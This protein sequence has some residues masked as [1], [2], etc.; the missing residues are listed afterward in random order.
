VAR[1]LVVDDEP[2]FRT[3]VALVLEIAGHRVMLAAD[4]LEALEAS[5]LFDLLVTDLMMPRMM[6]HELARRMRQRHPT[7]KVL[8][9]TGHTA[10]LFRNKGR[11]L[12]GEAVLTKPVSP[13]LLEDTVSLLL[14]GRIANVVAAAP[15]TDR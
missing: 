9:L 4:G 6:G 10:E 2:S 8:Y 11:L 3:F 12:A 5:G 14:S 1:I 15:T 13:E 7:V